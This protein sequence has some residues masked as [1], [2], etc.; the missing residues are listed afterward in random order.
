MTM[1]RNTMSDLERAVYDLAEAGALDASHAV[2]YAR[3]IGKLGRAGLLTK[4]DAGVYRA[5]RAASDT[6]P[7][8]PGTMPPP[9][10]QKPVAPAAPPAPPMG[11]LVVR[12]PQDW[13]DI[14][15]A[16]GPDR[17]TA[18]R[19]V[20]GRALAAGSGSRMRKAGT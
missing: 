8:K 20:L 7:P 13:L 10:P 18:L 9:A 11:T 4:D 14:L 3:S 16:M 6:R 1:K 5:V 15:D 19:T 17:S 2:L 12:V